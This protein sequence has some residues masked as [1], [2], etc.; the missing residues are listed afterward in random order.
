MAKDKLNPLK[1]T[2]DIVIEIDNTPYQLT[3]KTANKTILQ[4]LKSTKDKSK[5]QY[6]ESDDKRSQLYEKSS[7]KDINDSLLS[8]FGEKD[9]IS[10]KQKTAILIENKELVKEINSLNKEI[11]TLDKDLQDV[12]DAIED[13]YKEMFKQCVSGKD[14]VKFEKTIEDSGISYST[15]HLYLVEAVG[16]AQ[17]KK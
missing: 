6:A 5:E 3:Y 13:Y 12:N 2:Y 17:E 16:T 10:V 4:N 9:G 15:I 8:T 14:T 7:L 11:K 1:T